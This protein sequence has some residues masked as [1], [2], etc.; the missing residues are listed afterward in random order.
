[1]VMWLLDR[2]FSRYDTSFRHSVM[3]GFINF[4]ALGGLSLFSGAQ[5]LG[6][7]L[8]SWDTK[9]LRVQGLLPMIWGVWED[10]LS[11]YQG[12]CTFTFDIN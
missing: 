12:V 3:F 5:I 2:H 7:S 11:E 6:S 4:S 9:V 1:M 10:R 8:S